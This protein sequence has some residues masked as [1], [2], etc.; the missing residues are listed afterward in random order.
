[1]ELTEY[2]QEWLLE[3]LAAGP[4]VVKFTK[5][6]GTERV[7]P[8]TTNATIIMFKNNKLIENMP[9]NKNASTLV[10]FDLEKNEWRSFRTSS[11]KTVESI[12]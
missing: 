1:M 12:K 3:K 6:D 5:A 10:V 9:S 2:N 7:M 4:V 8:C 11:I